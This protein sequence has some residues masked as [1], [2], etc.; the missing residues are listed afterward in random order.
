LGANT[1]DWRTLNWA[2]I[3]A[4]R[5]RL[6][7]DGFSASTINGTLSALRGVAHRAWRIEQLSVQ[8]LE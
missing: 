5:N 3:E 7:M 6:R 4:V 8:E 1:L 2:D